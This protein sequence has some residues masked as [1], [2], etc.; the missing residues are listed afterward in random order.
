MQERIKII[1]AQL[2]NVEVNSI[3]P[4]SSP[5]N[6]ERWDSLKHMQLVLAVEDEFG[7]TFPDDD[8]PNLISLEKIEESVRG[9]MG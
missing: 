5:E 8:I 6:I 3:T 1:M 7:V 2:F 4:K 9:L